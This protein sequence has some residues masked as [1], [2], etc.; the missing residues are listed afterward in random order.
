MPEEMKALV[1]GRIG[2]IAFLILFLSLPVVVGFGMEV[3]SEIS[4]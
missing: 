4:Q 3:Q 1:K 2:L